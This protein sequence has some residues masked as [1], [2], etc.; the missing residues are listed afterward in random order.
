MLWIEFGLQGCRGGFV[1]VCVCVLLS[2]LVGNGGLRC[3]FT[4]V[5]HFSHFGNS[6][7]VISDVL[8]SLY[9]F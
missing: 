2:G 8:V 7:G 4:F 9:V 3:G 5:L 6:N 1:C